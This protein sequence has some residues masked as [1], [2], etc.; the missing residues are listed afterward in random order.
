MKTFDID[1]IL[2]QSFLMRLQ[3]LLGSDTCNIPICIMP[4]K[5][6]HTFGMKYLIDVIFCNKEM[7]VVRVE[8]NLKPNRHLECSRAHFVIERE[9]SDKYLP[10][11]GEKIRLNIVGI[12]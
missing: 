9:A 7:E 11:I 12:K 3:G 8:K 1:V 5:S 10:G 2:H 4:C 6:I